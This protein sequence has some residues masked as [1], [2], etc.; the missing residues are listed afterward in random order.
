VGAR[1][2]VASL[3]CA[4]THFLQS[5][6]NAFLCKNFDL[7]MLKN[8]YFLEK[9]KKI[10]EASGFRP[11]TPALLLPLTIKTLFSSFLPLN[12]FYYC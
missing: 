9:A 8:A 3:G 6:K 11:Q 4:S 2:P 10:A 7:N 5:F 1:A 12:A